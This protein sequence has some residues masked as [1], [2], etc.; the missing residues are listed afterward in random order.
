MEACSSESAGS[1]K[2]VDEVKQE[3]SGPDAQPSF[4]RLARG[5]AWAEP[6]VNGMHPDIWLKM[7]DIVN[8]GAIV[9]VR[10]LQWQGGLL[11]AALS[12][13]DARAT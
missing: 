11:L 3:T 7:L 10:S 1:D 12:F 6:R 4:I 9:L 8:P 2:N 13:K 5:R